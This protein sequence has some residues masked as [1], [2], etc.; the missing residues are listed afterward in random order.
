MLK[1]KDGSVVSGRAVAKELE[2]SLSSTEKVAHAL[3]CAGLVKAV[4]GAYGG[5]ILNKPPREITIAQVLEAVEI[6]LED[7][8]L[9]GSHHLI[10]TLYRQLVSHNYKLL[11]NI[12]LADVIDGNLPN[13]PVFKK[14]VVN[15]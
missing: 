6:G 12:S 8:E 9:A 11:A 5:Y 4:R 14:V 2:I 3:S 7:Q 13:H 15:Q 1:T 10:Q